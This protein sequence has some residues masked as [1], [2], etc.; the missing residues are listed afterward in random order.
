MICPMCGEKTLVVQT[1]TDIDE[2]VRERKCT[3]CGHRFYT[4]EKDID[5]P[6]GYEVIS[7]IRYKTKGIY[8]KKQR[9]KV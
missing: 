2:I 3:V 7:R 1:A 8:K 9:F 6:Y 5:A 4:S